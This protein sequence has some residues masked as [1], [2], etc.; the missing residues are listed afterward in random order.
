M[1]DEEGS[2]GGGPSMRAFFANWTTYDAPFTT[3]LRMAVSN[4]LTKFRTKQNCCGNHGQ[5]GC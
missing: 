2:G 1:A 4:N 3:K 5:P